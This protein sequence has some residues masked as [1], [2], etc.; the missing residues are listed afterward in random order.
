[1]LFLSFSGPGN[2]DLPR[3]TLASLGILGM[4]ISF[5]TAYLYS[6]ELFPT[7]VRNVGVGSGSMSARVGSMVAP[8][9]ASLVSTNPPFVPYPI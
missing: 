1:M 5:P 4:G 8:F 2:S 3:V 6:G 9:V 7:V